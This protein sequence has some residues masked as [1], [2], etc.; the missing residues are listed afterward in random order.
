MFCLTPRDLEGCILGC[1]DGPASFNAQATQQGRRVISCDPMYQFS[2]PAIRQRIDET[3]EVI[4]QQTRLCAAQYRWDEFGDVESLLRHR[5]AAMDRFLA[6]FEGTLADGRGRYVTGALPHLP[7]AEGSF[8][9]ALVS[10][11]LFLYSQ[12]L[13]LD[14]HIAAILDLLRVASEVRIFPLLTLEHQPSPHLPPVLQR[15]QSSGY[16]TQIIATDYEFQIAPDHFGNRMLSIR[17][18]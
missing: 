15:L 6:D 5:M 18:Q 12:Q 1:G 14:F 10:H 7:F 8:A 17:H 13:D 2:C 3:S 4:A 11:L 9:L 16:V